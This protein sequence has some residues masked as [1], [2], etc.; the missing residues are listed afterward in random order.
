M[1][2]VR[3]WYVFKQHFPAYL[4]PTSQGIIL[5]FNLKTQNKKQQSSLWNTQNGIDNG[6]NNPKSKQLQ[7]SPLFS[8]KKVFTFLSQNWHFYVNQLLSGGY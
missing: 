5:S 2:V 6:G 4:N 1:S 3:V 8:F 7:P